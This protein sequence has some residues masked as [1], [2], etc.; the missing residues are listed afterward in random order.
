MADYIVNLFNIYLAEKKVK[1]KPKKK[2]YKQIN[3]KKNKKTKENS[4][5]L[6]NILLI[7][8]IYN[9]NFKLGYFE[10]NLGGILF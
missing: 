2:K 3:Q 7:P 4:Y 8:C 10:H 1:F 5:K 9:R 6:T